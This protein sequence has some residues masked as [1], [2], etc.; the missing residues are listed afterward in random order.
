MKAVS[1]LLQN[2]GSSDQVQ[3]ALMHSNFLLPQVQIDMTA[4]LQL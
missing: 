1:H 2:N 3:Q 4:E